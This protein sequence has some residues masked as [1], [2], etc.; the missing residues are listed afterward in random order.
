MSFGPTPARRYYL[1]KSIA[2]LAAVLVVFLIPFFVEVD[3]FGRTFAYVLAGVLALSAGYNFWLYRRSHP[4]SKVYEHPAA[5][6]PD[7]RVKYFRKILFLNYLAFPFLA[8][9]TWSEIK[10][11]ESGKT[12]SLNLWAPLMFI[13][14]QW[15]TWPAIISILL[16]GVILVTALRRKMMHLS[17]GDNRDRC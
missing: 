13:Y 3:D 16:A 6:P 7:L 5:A 14:E 9:I 11:F 10:E 1:G 15:G 8:F 12:E 17:G 4:E 2:L